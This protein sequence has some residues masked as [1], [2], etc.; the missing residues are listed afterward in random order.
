MHRKNLFDRRQ[1]IPAVRKLD[2][3]DLVGIA[4]IWLMAK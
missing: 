3:R 1:A 2:Q 4:S